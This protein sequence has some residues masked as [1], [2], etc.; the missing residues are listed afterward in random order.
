MKAKELKQKTKT[1]LMNMLGEYR[2]KIYYCRI[3]KSNAQLKNVKLLQQYKKDI[4]RILTIIKEMDIT[5]KS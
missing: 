5:N 4:A 2:S 3:D 1:E